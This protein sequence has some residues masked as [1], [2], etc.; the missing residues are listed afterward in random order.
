MGQS[1]AMAKVE[2][3]VQGAGAP[4]NRSCVQDSGVGCT[5]V[6]AALC[7]QRRTGA[8]HSGAD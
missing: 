3:R 2:G 1:L 5:R 4:R 6:I 8:I 7:R